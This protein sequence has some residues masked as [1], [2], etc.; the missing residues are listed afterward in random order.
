M[1]GRAAA[2][3]AR[4][5]DAERTDEGPVALPP[6][7]A[8]TAEYV[9][10]I[11]GTSMEGRRMFDGDLALVDQRQTA[12]TGDVVA[13][14]VQDEQTDEV[15]ANIKTLTELDGELWLLSANP[16]VPRSPLPELASSGG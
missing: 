4:S 6:E 16:A 3:P 2:G 1:L 10:R 11:T 14:I 15:K 7:L 5:T 9:V 13:V 8:G 12:R